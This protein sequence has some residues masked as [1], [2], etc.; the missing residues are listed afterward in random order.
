M[1]S[2]Q[3]DYPNLY[4]LSRILVT[5]TVGDL[6]SL[7]KNKYNLATTFYFKYFYFLKQ[8]KI[9]KVL[10]RSESR[11]CST[12][13]C[14]VGIFTLADISE[15]HDPGPGGW[16]Q[17]ILPGGRRSHETTRKIG[18]QEAAGVPEVL[19]RHQ[20]L[21][22]RWHRVTRRSAMWGL[23]WDIV[24]QILTTNKETTTLNVL[25]CPLVNSWYMINIYRWFWTFSPSNTG[26]RKLLF[27]F[28]LHQSH[29]IR[30]TRK[31]EQTI[32]KQLNF[33]QCTY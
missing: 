19:Q 22:L 16:E 28:A 31:A 25:Q 18:H 15:D 23:I 2:Q 11:V 6:K 8:G 7:Q 24:L 17:S 10:Y 13:M 12:I 29:R 14:C 32:T 21:R 3:W 27:L 5:V 1:A 4:F 33:Q 30:Q 26:S 20:Q 9:S